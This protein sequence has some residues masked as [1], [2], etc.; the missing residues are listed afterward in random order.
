MRAELVTLSLFLS[1]S[2]RSPPPPLLH[3]PLEVGVVMAQSGDSVSF[4]PAVPFWGTRRESCLGLR[5]W[6]GGVIFPQIWQ[7]LETFLVVTSRG[8]ENCCWDPSGSVLN[9]Q[10]IHRSTGQLPPQRTPR[11]VSHPEAEKCCCKWNLDVL[12][13]VITELASSSWITVSFS[14][15]S[16]ISKI[17]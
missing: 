1:Q 3:L 2:S 7:C 13:K 16:N 8:R 9:T 12:L 10:D 6:R 14:T 5:T 17:F 4:A 11:G 15:F